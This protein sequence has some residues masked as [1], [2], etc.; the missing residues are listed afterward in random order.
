MRNASQTNKY[1]LVFFGYSQPGI[2]IEY[3]VEGKLHIPHFVNNR[4]VLLGEE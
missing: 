1:Y 2:V 3:G 4:T